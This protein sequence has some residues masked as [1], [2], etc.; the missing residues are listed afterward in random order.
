MRPMTPMQALLWMCWRL[1][2]RQLLVQM[3][4][5]IA[6]VAVM[7]QMN[8]AVVDQD[9]GDVNAASRG[10]IIGS[11][12][13][14]WTVCIGTSSEMQKGRH[15]AGFMFNQEFARPISTAKLVLIPMANLCLVLLIAYFV[16]TLVLHL[17][18]G[19]AAPN[20]PM[21]FLV[22]ES[23]VLMSTVIWWTDSALARA[24]AWS[25]V[26]FLPGIIPRR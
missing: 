11:L 6:V 4:I 5:T 22:I 12:I 23:V 24:A 26:F 20:L 18:Y 21:A 10:L 17:I 13:M 3:I 14:L 9:L 25:L 7:M 1:S 16:P 19:L 8:F 2:Y 15:A